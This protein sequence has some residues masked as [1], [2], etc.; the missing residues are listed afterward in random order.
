MRKYLIK[1]N[2]EKVKNSIIDCN[3]KIIE[4]L[5]FFNID[6]VV[7]EIK[8][9]N[10]ISFK[11]EFHD[12]FKYDINSYTTGFI[13][14][15]KDMVV[16]L[17]YNDYKYTDHRNEKTYD[18]FIKTI[19]HEIVH[20]VHSIACKHNYPANELWEGIAVYLSN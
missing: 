11:K 2:D 16:V 19:I 15:D 18:D 20:V 7:I 4:I 8:V 12:Y 5:D 1:S 14:D 10:Y 3:K 13:E 9:L 6:S 17:D